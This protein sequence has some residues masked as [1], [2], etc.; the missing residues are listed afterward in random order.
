MS[1][2]RWSPWGSMA[3]ILTPL[4][5]GCAQLSYAGISCSFVIHREESH[6]MCRGV[7]N[8]TCIGYV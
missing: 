4:E 5:R 8:C 1:R 3:R 7:F 2:L 6:P